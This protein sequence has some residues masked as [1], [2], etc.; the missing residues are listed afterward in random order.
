SGAIGAFPLP[1][2]SLRVHHVAHG[3]SQR[4]LRERKRADRSAGGGEPQGTTQR[5]QSSLKLE[6]HILPMKIEDDIGAQVI[7]NKLYFYV[8]HVGTYL[9]DVRLRS[10]ALRLSRALQFQVC[11]Q[12]GIE[13]ALV[14]AQGRGSA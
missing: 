2:S 9:F 8:L 12:I 6:A 10:L 14:Q 4:R 1:Q 13:L 5:A 11:C 7:P 3:V